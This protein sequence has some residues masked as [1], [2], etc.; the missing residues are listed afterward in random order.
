M[1]AVDRARLHFNALNV[2]K[3]YVHE[4]SDD[5]GKPLVVCALPLTVKDRDKI[6]RLN[7]RYGATVECM[8]HILILFARDE[9]GEPLFSLEDKPVLLR[10]ADPAVILGLAQQIAELV[11]PEGLKK[12]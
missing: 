4:W 5:E 6:L 2:R 9:D 10:Q 1:R 8:I 11:P 3:F 7:G 12:N